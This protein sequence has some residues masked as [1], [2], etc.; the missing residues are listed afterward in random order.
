MLFFF[1]S[2]IKKKK[3]V[4]RKVIIRSPLLYS[5]A[6]LPPLGWLPLQAGPPTD[7]PQQ[8]PAHILPV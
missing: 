4:I 8:F 6:A 7:G 1:L 5:A 3:K 2:Y